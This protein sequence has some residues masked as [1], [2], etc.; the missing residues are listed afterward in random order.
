LKKTILLF[1][2]QLIIASFARSGTA[3]R[4]LLTEPQ[5]SPQAVA[6]FNEFES[7]VP[8]LISLATKDR[9]GWVIRGISKSHRESVLL[10]TLKLA[11]AAEW[12][13][14]RLGL[15]VQKM[16]NMAIVHD[17]PESKSP[18]YLPG[19][20]SKG[21][22]FEIEVAIMKSYREVYEGYFDEAY[23]LWI[24]FEEQKTEEA[25]VLKQLDKLDPILQS[26]RYLR[27]GYTNVADFITT[28]HQVITH[29]LLVECLDRALISE[30]DPY[31]AAFPS[32]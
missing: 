15:D 22:K 23:D 21:D 31:S 11:S 14:K 8:D 29:P 18:D 28:A 32:N 2:S 20:I 19:E 17:F 9:R 3:C 7:K 27:M 5:V 10:H 4:Y 25:Q 13:A 1:Y 12:V 16:Q 24:E 26:I 6:R 30:E